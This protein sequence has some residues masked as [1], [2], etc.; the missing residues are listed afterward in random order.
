[1]DDAVARFV[2]NLVGRLYGPF[3]FRFVLQP[4]M[5]MLYATRDGLAD[6]REGRPP[7][8]W[9]IFTRPGERRRLL[10]E[11][12]T[13]VT[14]VIALGVVMDGI[15]QFVVFRWLYPLELAV[16]VLGLAF[17][18]YVLLRGP[19]ERMAT[20]WTTRKIRRKPDLLKKET[21]NADRRN[22]RAGSGR[23]A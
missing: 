23:Y 17:V 11:G 2:S 1:M 16:I 20:W 7:Y 13:A 8:F 12:W 21:D 22:G 15:Y 6:A 14:R 9:T 19:I 3:S 5:A 4:V 18:P 10:R